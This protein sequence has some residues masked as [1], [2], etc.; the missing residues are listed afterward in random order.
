MYFV[1]TLENP[2]SNPRRLTLHSATI[3]FS[4]TLKQDGEI[5]SEEE[6]LL[7]IPTGEYTLDSVKKAIDTAVHVGI[8]PAQ[9]VS[10]G[11]SHMLSLQP[12]RTANKALRQLLAIPESAEG[13]RV[14]GK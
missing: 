5:R 8:Q 13:S 6:L 9:I 10:S 12:G 7:T 4:R 14:E 11:S 1:V 2:L 3:P